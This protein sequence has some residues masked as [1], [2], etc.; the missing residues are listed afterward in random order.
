MDEFLVK[1]DELK[2]ELLERERQFAKNE[3]NEKFEPVW[4]EI[5]S[6][7]GVKNDL[8]CFVNIDVSEFVDL[9]TEEEWLNYFEQLK[10]KEHFQ[11]SMETKGK[12]VL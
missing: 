2:K 1:F 5:E 4:T 11:A 9:R 7:L 10:R 8:N 3:E 12:R 6:T